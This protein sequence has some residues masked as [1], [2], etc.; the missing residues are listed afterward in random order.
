MQVYQRLGEKEE[1]HSGGGIDCW[2][3][4]V[5]VM[6]INLQVLLLGSE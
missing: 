1:S 3:R 5:V 6:V 4:Y 2:R